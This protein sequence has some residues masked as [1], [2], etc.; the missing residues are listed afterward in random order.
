MKG[1]NLITEFD[2]S[3]FEETQTGNLIYSNDEFNFII[4]NELHTCNLELNLIGET[5]EDQDTN[6]CYF[7]YTF[8]ILTIT[9]LTDQEG[10]FVELTDEQ[11]TYL[12]S[13][14]KSQI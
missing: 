6:S 7:D 12:K 10:E 14:I 2:I 4:S 13:L 9:D 3:D 11:E 1:I 5:F 8:K